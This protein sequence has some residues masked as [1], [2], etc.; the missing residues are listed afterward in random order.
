MDIVEI[1]GKLETCVSILRKMENFNTFS[2]FVTLG[3]STYLTIERFSDVY[4][5]IYFE[6]TKGKDSAV[7]E[8]HNNMLR[9]VIGPKE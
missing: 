6:I 1:A 8:T 2:V 5:L 7:F 9:I 3:N 4:D